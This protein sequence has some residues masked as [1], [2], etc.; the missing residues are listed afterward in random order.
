MSVYP[1]K[2]RCKEYHEIIFS[3]IADDLY[4]DIHGCYH[5]GAG[6]CA[7]CGKELC[8]SCGAIENKICS[9]CRGE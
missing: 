2:I 7:K 4:N 3:G 5:H 1:Y 8:Q 9:D 6:R